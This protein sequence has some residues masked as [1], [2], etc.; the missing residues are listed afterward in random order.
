MTDAL[1]VFA[2]VPT[3]GRVKTRLT[4]E[5][6][7]QEAASLYEAFLLDALALYASLDVDVRLY[8]APSD[9]SFDSSLIG[10]TIAIFEQGGEGLGARMA[11]AFVETFAA[12]YERVAIVGTD[13]PTLPPSFIDYAFESLSTPRGISIGPAEDGGY[14]LLAMNDLVPEVFRGMAYSHDN[15]FRETLDRIAAAGVPV[16]V[17]PEWYDVDTPAQLCRLKAELR[18][19]ANAAPRTKKQI[20]EL[21]KRYAWLNN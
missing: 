20:D 17:L 12:G 13:H 10:G 6:T 8:L 2:K 19:A 16:T 11:R 9:S 15:V 14:Y 4:P 1:I 18:E 3:A 21:A 7:G 5:L